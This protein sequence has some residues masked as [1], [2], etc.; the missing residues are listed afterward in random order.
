MPAQDSESDDSLYSRGAVRST[1]VAEPYPPGT[2][3]TASFETLD[4]D[5]AA[6]VVDAGVVR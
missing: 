5:I 2:V 6:L 1:E 4:N 3:K